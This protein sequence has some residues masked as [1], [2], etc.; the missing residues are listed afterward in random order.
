MKNDPR[1]IAV[2]MAE[3]FSSDLRA[4]IYDNK[5]ID[6]R[7]VKRIIGLSGFDAYIDRHAEGNI[8][9]YY[10]NPYKIRKKCLYEKCVDQPTESVKT[11][12][13]KCIAQEMERVSRDLA[14]TIID[15][16]NSLQA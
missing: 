16:A 11:C 15:I 4:F 13:S 9:V 12:I 2:R 1:E 8:V 3:S 6:S 7:I 14:E 5:L 10:I